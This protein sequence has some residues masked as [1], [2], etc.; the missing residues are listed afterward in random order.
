MQPSHAADRCEL[1]QASGSGS[2]SPWLPS[3]EEEGYGSSE[4]EDFV[5]SLKISVT[6]VMQTFLRML[7]P[8]AVVRGRKSAGK[9]DAGCAM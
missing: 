7:S 8:S 3:A 6:S 1:S 9:Y 5:R 2:L 4:I